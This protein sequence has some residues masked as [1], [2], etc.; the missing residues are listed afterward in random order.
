M[1]E[2]EYLCGNDVHDVKLYEANR[3]IINKANKV[4]ID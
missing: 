3:V 2:E 1:S 4:H